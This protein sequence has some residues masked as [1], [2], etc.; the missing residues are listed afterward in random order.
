QTRV[1]C[2]VYKASNNKLVCTK[3][4]MRNRI[5]LINSTQYLA[6]VQVPLCT[7]PESQ[8]AK[9]TPKKK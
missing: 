8:G 3:T 9:L 1:I 7:V 6:K 4:L 2:V 5:V